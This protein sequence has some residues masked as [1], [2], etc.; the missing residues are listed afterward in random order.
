MGSISRYITPLVINSLGGGHTHTHT[1]TRVHT[2]THTNDPHRFNFKQPGA[3][4]PQAGAR[5]VQK[6]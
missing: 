4:R 2:H 5:L 6:A 3:H 1:H